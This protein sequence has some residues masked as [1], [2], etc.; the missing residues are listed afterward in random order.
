VI[1]GNQIPRLLKAEHRY[2]GL[3]LSAHAGRLSR[4]VWPI[5]RG[6]PFFNT[7]LDGNIG[8]WIVFDE[9]QP[10]PDDDGYVCRAATVHETCL[11]RI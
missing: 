6:R 10:D 1:F 11:E 3:F 4:I 5:H 2:L 8:Y 7:L 9:P